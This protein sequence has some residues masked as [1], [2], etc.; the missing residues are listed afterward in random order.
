MGEPEDI[1]LGEQDGVREGGLKGI[2]VGGEIIVGLKV[3]ERDR[4]TVGRLVGEKVKG[5]LGKR[6]VN[7][8]GFR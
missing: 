7:M 4:A 8:L 3:G 6:V 1:Q 2:L 5:L